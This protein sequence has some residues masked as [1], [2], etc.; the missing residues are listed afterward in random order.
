MKTCSKNY[1]GGPTRVTSK[2][3]SCSCLRWCY[4]LK[5]KTNISVLNTQYLGSEGK[6]VRKITGYKTTRLLQM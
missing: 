3:T 2:E 1:A 6:Q 5:N 4:T